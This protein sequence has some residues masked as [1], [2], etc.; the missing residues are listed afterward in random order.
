VGAA[1]LVPFLAA[2]A[3]LL[4]A[5]VEKIRTP[6]YTRDAFDA[7]GVPGGAAAIRALGT[8]E[9]VAG[10]AA[11]ASAFGLGAPSVAAIA[12]ASL[13][14]LFAAAILRLLTSGTPVR[15]CGCLGS[16]DTPPSYLHVGVNVACAL[17]A[18]AYAATPETLRAATSGEPLAYLIA[19]FGAGLAVYLAQALIR[20]LPALWKMRKLLAGSSAE[21]G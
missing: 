21:G 3:L 1:V 6:H 17:F 18:C 13:Y 14:V 11:V 2:A 15:S 7:L 12:V 8:V 10:A 4:V 16:T 20:W 19:L 9:I 5:G